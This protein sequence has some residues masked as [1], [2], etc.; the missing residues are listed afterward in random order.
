[1]LC[2]ELRDKGIAFHIIIIDS[3]SFSS[4]YRNINSDWFFC[5][6]GFR[7][8]G[9]CSC[10]WRQLSPGFVGLQ[11][12]NA[13][14]STRVLITFLVHVH[15]VHFP[16]LLASSFLFYLLLLPQEG[17]ELVLVVQTPNECH[18]QRDTEQVV[19]VDEEAHAGE[20]PVKTESLGVRVRE[21]WF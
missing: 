14:K 19:C 15:T 17:F 12:V 16:L 7:L 11:A 6:F 20:C 3:S 13:I 1:V 4:I 10:K 2:E 8:I 5:L 21:E 9:Y 18:D